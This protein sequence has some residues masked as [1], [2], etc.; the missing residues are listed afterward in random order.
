MLNQ[1]TELLSACSL[2]CL[3]TDFA[4]QQQKKSPWAKYNFVVVQVPDSVPDFG[5][6]PGAGP[7]KNFEILKFGNLT[8]FKVFS[9]VNSVGVKYA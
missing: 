4:Q 1:W 9:D 7:K 2:G 8:V 5:A 6:G 3:L